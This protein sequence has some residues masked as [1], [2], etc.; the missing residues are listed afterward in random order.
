M[1]RDLD[2]LATQPFDLV[3]VGGG[4]HGICTAYDATLRGLRVALLERGDFGGATSANS[5]KIIHG[6]IRYLQHADLY[7]IRESSRERTALFGVAPHLAY[8]LP[9]RPSGL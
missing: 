2:T 9:V 5:F 3:V 4:L 7:R 8:P 1:H 6:G